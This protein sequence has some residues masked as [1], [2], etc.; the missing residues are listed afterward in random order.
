[1]ATD[2]FRNDACP[3]A[4][5]AVG[6]V[7]FLDLFFSHIAFQNK[8]SE[9]VGCR[10]I[11]VCAGLEGS[12]EVRV[13]GQIPFHD[14]IHG[15]KIVLFIIVQQRLPIPVQLESPRIAAKIVDI[16]RSEGTD[17]FIPLF[18]FRKHYDR[19]FRHGKASFP[20]LSKSISVCSKSFS[21]AAMASISSAP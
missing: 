1:M 7:Q 15:P 9:S 20:T 6:K 8:A 18:A 16:K 19:P 12:A 10:K 2:E 11:E 5:A 21:T 3:A 17:D 4:T 14:D 13:I